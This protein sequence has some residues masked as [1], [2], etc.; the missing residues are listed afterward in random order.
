MADFSG[1]PFPEVGQRGFYLPT[2]PDVPVGPGF[3]HLPT[4]NHESDGRQ[5]HELGLLWSQ[6]VH[7]PN[8]NGDPIADGER[9]WKRALEIRK[10]HNSYDELK[11]ADRHSADNDRKGVVRSAASAIDAILR[12]YCAEWSVSLPDDDRP[13]N[14]K[15]DRV[16]QDANRPKYSDA[17]PAGSKDVLRLYR[18]RSSMHDGDCCY[19]DPDTKKRVDVTI[20]AARALLEAAKRCVLWMD[21]QA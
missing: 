20:E 7:I 11:D 6:C 4:F 1:N 2:S 13:F 15:I 9:I 16:L 17:D 5:F 10:H 21:S 3:V 14:E 8:P 12:H 19:N 18:A